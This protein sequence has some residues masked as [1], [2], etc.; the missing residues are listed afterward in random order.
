MSVD[1]VV[2]SIQL[3]A[4]EPL[5]KGT[6]PFERLGP[7]FEPVKV[8][9]LLLP[10]SYGIGC[11]AG[12]DTWVVD[13]RL[14]AEL[15]GGFEMALFVEQDFNRLGQEVLR[16]GVWVGSDCSSNERNGVAR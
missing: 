15:R 5:G 8:A 2:A 7:R 14:S 6:I 12:I 4:D 3:A 16:F 11:G 13:I 9:S 10:K 1:A